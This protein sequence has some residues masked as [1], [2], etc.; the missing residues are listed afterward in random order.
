MSIISIMKKLLVPIIGII[1]LVLAGIGATLYHQHTSYLNTAPIH[2]NQNI[3]IAVLSDTHV[4]AEQLHDNGTAWK[5]FENTSA[6]MDINYNT[7][8]LQATI[9]Q[10]LQTKPAIVIIAGDLTSNGEARNAQYLANQ[11]TRLRK[12]GIKTYVIPGNHD[13][14][15][16]Q[17]RSFKGAKT[18]L[19]DQM[20]P[21]DFQTIFQNDGYTQAS[22]KDA[23]SLSYLVKPAKKLWFLMLDSNIYDHNQALQKSADDGYF[24]PAT[25]RY[26]TASLKAAKKAG[27]TIIPVLH[28]SALV[29]GN[30]AGHFAVNNY[31]TFDK[32]LREYG[33]HLTISGHMHAQS[34]TTQAGLT[35][36]TQGALPVSPHYYGELTYDYH[37]HQLAYHAKPIDLLTTWTAKY[38]SSKA[39]QMLAT[40]HAALYQSGRRFAERMLTTSPAT[41]KLSPQ[42]QA[43]Y[44]DAFAQINVATFAGTTSKSKKDLTLL[45]TIPDAELR[46]ILR[47]SL[48][49]QD[50]LNWSSTGMTP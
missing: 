43:T 35:D 23:A 49:S 9:T 24:K 19:T 25:G 41:A 2:A 8:I 1:L 11:L 21:A 46:Q 38:G 29:H 20:S 18:N 28:H 13:I 50:N 5:T 33:V 32:V 37:N 31:Q 26:I 27:A 47:V 14:N 39:K 22:T 34:I 45:R 7:Q 17:A 40:D 4:L 42:K 36:I 10:L 16:P 15:N 3:K 44:A 6:G 30:L 12:A 48:S